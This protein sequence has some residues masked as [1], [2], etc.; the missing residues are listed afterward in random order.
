MTASMFHEWDGTGINAQPKNKNLK[1]DWNL[2]VSVGGGGVVMMS[3][4]VIYNQFADLTP[5]DTL[6]LR[7]TGGNLRI[8]ANRLIDHGSYKQI[9]LNFDS[10][11]P[12]WSDEWGAL[13]V[14]LADVDNT[15]TNKGEDRVENFVHVN[16][17]KVAG[18]NKSTILRSAYL[19]PRV[20][21]GIYRVEEDKREM[22]DGIYY[23]LLGQ[24]VKNPTKGIYIR[25]GKKIVVK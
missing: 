24:P 1:V 21:Q 17:L 19:V 13:L 6:V 12:Y 15:L 16:A 14:P 10:S 9:V 3:S 11:D 2:N 18:G 20:P 22:G 7:G 25:N 4:S 8:I 23:N 5:Y